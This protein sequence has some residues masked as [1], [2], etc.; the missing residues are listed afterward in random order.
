MR[1]CGQLLKQPAV[2]CVERI[3]HS[4]VCTDCVIVKI[5]YS[6]DFFYVCFSVV[7]IFNHVKPPPLVVQ[8]GDEAS[9]SE[10]WSL[11][12]PEPW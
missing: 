2:G 3:Q 9:K 7:E 4:L 12:L 6:C 8:R 10:G 1:Y 5:F 11:S